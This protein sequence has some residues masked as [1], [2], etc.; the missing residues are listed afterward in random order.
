MFL[1]VRMRIPAVWP[2]KQHETPKARMNEF[3]V[4]SFAATRNPGEARTLQIGN[5]FSYFTRHDV[6]MRQLT[7]FASKLHG[8]VLNSTSP[9]RC[10]SRLLVKS[11]N[12]QAVGRRLVAAHL[13]ALGD[14]SGTDSWFVG[15]IALQSGLCACGLA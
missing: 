5:Q 13:Q 2:G 10:Q 14:A 7:V 9:S 6:I 12:L 1:L 8:G 11:G 15:D 4:A 3:A